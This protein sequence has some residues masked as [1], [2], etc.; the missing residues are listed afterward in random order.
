MT[1]QLPYTLQQ[2]QQQQ[3]QQQQQQ[4][5]TEQAFL[6][7]GLS[8]SNFTKLQQHLL[9]NNKG[10]LSSILNTV[11]KD[12]TDQKI[13]QQQAQIQQLQQQ[14]QQQVQQQIQHVQQQQQQH[15]QQQMSQQLQHSL[16]Q[17]QQGRQGSPNSLN[18]SLAL[19]QRSM[20]PPL[21][22]PSIT[23]IQ[24]PIQQPL[25]QPPQHPLQQPHITIPQSYNYNY[26]YT[27]MGDMNSPSIPISPLT[28]SPNNANALPP[29]V[30]YSFINS[31]QQGGA[32]PNQINSS[33]NIIP[34]MNPPPPP[35]NNN[36]LI[37]STTVTSTLSSSPSNPNKI[38]KTSS[39]PLISSD[40]GS[41]PPPPGASLKPLPPSF[42][43]KLLPVSPLRASS[44][45]PSDPSFSQDQLL[46]QQANSNKKPMV[47]TADLLKMKQS[48][49]ALKLGIPPSTFSKRWRESL[50]HRK[51]PYRKHRKLE[52]SL[53]MLKLLQQKGHQENENIDKILAEREE[54]LRDAVVYMNEDELDTQKGGIST[55]KKRKHSDEDD[56][57]DSDV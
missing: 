20:Q 24:Q 16:S 35:P 32:L 6:P 4:Q 12:P 3:P 13:A 40:K 31:M 49:A 52:K 21:Q 11:D 54:N 46:A 2:Q 43:H 15:L 44:V 38:L 53:K 55:K 29:N 14:V 23:S 41:P 56:D 36:N 50:P 26:Y 57:D 8:A 19:Q 51:W 37:T 22:Q 9:A 27:G 10:S 45:S 17:Q 18:P 47:I 5:P 7:A 33:I 42:V 34:Y 25:Q 1:P 30:V 48:E 28:P 39:P